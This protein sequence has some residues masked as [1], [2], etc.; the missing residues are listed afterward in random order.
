MKLYKENMALYAVTDRSWLKDEAISK[1]VEE[2]IKGGATFIQLREKQISKEN[3]IKEAEAVKRITDKYKIPFVINDN[4]EVAIAVNADGVHIGQEDEDLVVVRNKLG[5][6]KI[7]GVSAHNL[8]EA[9]KAEENGADYLGVGAVFST[10]TKKNVINISYE[11]IENICSNIKIPVVA[12]G[13]ISKENIIELKGRGLSGV[14]VVSAIFAE[15]NI[16]AAA[17]KMLMLSKKIT[18]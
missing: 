11:E 3:L 12:I 9:L 4:V 14:A 7:I 16:E 15:E 5:P 8:K 10:A 18:N 17:K 13:G 2:A 6:D 1:K